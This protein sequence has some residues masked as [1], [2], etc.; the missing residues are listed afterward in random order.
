MLGPGAGAMPTCSLRA[1]T[2]AGR[3]LADGHLR[4]LQHLPS[5]SACSMPSKH[6]LAAVCLAAD[7]PA[8]L[9]IPPPRPKRKAAHPYPRAAAPLSGLGTCATSTGAGTT[10]HR[11]QATSSSS[12]GE[13]GEHPTEGQTSSDSQSQDAA[14][15]DQGLGVAGA[16]IMQRSP[17]TLRRLGS[18]SKSGTPSPVVAAAVKRARHG[19]RAQ[20]VHNGRHGGRE[21]TPTGAAR[22]THMLD[23][24]GPNAELQAAPVDP[25]DSDLLVTAQGTR[26]ATPAPDPADILAEL[27][28]HSPSLHSRLP[29]SVT[30]AAV[31]LGAASLPAPSSRHLAM[32]V[33]TRSG[34]GS[35]E[36]SMQIAGGA[37]AA[38]AAQMEEGEAQA[39]ELLAAP[40]A[41]AASAAAAAAAAAVVAAAGYQVH[42]HLQ[43]SSVP[44]EGNVAQA[45]L[46]HGTLEDE[47]GLLDSH[48]WPALECMN[49]LLELH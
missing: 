47:V 33:P 41:A 34:T 14:E 13:E 17:A 22:S 23:L 3:P 10:A 24:S 18:K 6:V 25:A 46:L 30:A 11:S 37:V 45:A 42:A 43:V 44:S 2:K 35:L 9:A 32:S 40:V 21:R 8:D 49:C 20:Q 7:V 39:I 29:G 4:C 16:A 48:S 1:S 12:L 38:D 31:L 5:L 15:E 26:Q 27:Q 19:G 36:N 28:E